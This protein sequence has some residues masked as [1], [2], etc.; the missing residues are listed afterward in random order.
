MTGAEVAIPESVVVSPLTGEAKELALLT[1]DEIKT[2]VEQMETLA[3]AVADA[4][5]KLAEEAMRRK[6]AN[7]E[8]PGLEVSRR[9]TWRSGEVGAALDKL[10]RD[11]KLPTDREFYLRQ[12]T[13]FKAVGKNLNALADQLVTNGDTEAAGV[14]LTA[15]RQSISVKVKS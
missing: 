12:E 4:K 1:N 14:L 6:N 5:R 9:N 7:A 8:V 3:A 10:E 13:A 11:G 2:G 15:R